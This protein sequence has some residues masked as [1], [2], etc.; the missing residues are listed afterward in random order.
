M[1]ISDWSADMCSSDLYGAA[2]ASGETAAR[3]QAGRWTTESRNAPSGEQYGRQAAA[4]LADPGVLKPHRFEQLEQPIARAALIPPPR[5][6]QPR[7]GSVVVS[8][9]FFR[10][11]PFS[12]S[13]H[14]SSFI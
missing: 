11:S 4:L 1:R 2:A 10:L 6:D 5:S 9:C 12:Y 8:M 13:I 3:R 7:L 14:T